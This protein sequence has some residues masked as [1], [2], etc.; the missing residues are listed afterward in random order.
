MAISAFG[1]KTTLPGE[2]ELQTMLGPHLDW[3]QRITTFMLASYQLPGLLQY[4]GKNYGWHLYY[5]RGSKPLL[6]LYPQEE[7]LVA[8]VVLGK[9]EIEKASVLSLGE[10][11][12]KALRETPGLHDGKWLFL[13]PQTGQDVED[14]LQLILTKSKPKK[15]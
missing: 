13:K 7:G 4:G 9:T 2:T 11:V 6:S 1:D 14:I 8:Q 3:C 15:E 12:A 5:K 10:T